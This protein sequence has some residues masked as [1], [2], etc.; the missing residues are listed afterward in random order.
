[1][2]LADTTTS[3]MEYYMKTFLFRKIHNYKY[4]SV[5]MGHVFQQLQLSSFGNSILTRLLHLLQTALVF[6]TARRILR[7]CPESAEHKH[8]PQDEGVSTS[9]DMY[10]LL[11][12]AVSTG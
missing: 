7:P 5:G 11:V 6:C 3:S 8:G 10:V 4:K 12:F 9:K 2:D 1:M